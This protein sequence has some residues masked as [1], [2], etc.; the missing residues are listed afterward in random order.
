MSARN[1][2]IVAA[3]PLAAA[4]A[5]C[6]GA[7]S[8]GAGPV[9]F[10][11]QDPVWVVNDRA[12]VPR[13]PEERKFY[14][15][16]Y[17]LDGYWYGRFDRWAQM[18]PRRRA[19]NVN[20]L[21]EVPDST[22]FTNRIGVRDM[23]PE[24][25]AVGP[26]VTG[27]PEDHRPWVIKSS[28]VGGVTPGFIVED[29]RGI[30]YV[31]KFDMKGIPEVETGADVIVQRLLWAV[32]YNVPEDY[33]VEFRRED[34]V[35]APDAVVVDPMGNKE[36]MDAAFVDRQLAL[37]NVNP[38]GTIRGLA[39]QFL[40]GVPIGGHARDGVRPDDPNDTI[41]HQ[42]RREL[43]GQYAIFS[44]LEQTD[45]KE[46]NSLDVYVSDPQNPAVKYVVHYFLDFGK[47][48]GVQ[49]FINGRRFVGH[50]YLVD[51][52]D[53]GKSL[54]SL[55]M[56]Q[57]PWESRSET[58]LIGVGLLESDVFD[59]GDWHAYSPSYFP[60]L[61]ADRFDNFW[62][63]KILIRFTREHIRAAVE[64]A[65]L[66]DPRAAAYIVQTLIQ[67]Q[68]KVARYWFDR[69]NPLDRFEVR[70]EGGAWSLCFDDLAIVYNLERYSRTPTYYTARAYGR[71][72]RATGWQG[73]V[74]AETGGRTCMS[75]PPAGGADAYT[76]VGIFTVRRG[77]SLP[78]TRVHLA[79]N[80]QT[81]APR[82]IGLERL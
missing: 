9:R 40:P 43:R 20:S 75:V 63:A 23:T 18:R 3:L 55:G 44:W 22:W 13:Q 57:R 79:R 26:N 36:P 54:L 58:G 59:P 76:I 35:L 78:G 1:A 12:N 51:L 41:P 49:P 14:K 38:D 19:A 2:L 67:R 70:E 56:W 62:G 52:A 32:G 73:R 16:L 5:A 31:L 82:V 81:G 77:P 6:G 64:Q 45:A 80:P 33:V 47:A 21:G 29:Q 42:L 65:R 7:T 11:N 72:G 50:A 48:L 15:A 74:N 34:L 28:K 61:D 10:A 46:D 27:S 69:V 71:D 24:E 4:L 30:K 39:S 68:R 8:A 37:I 66:S 53:M 17:H 60:F 25:I